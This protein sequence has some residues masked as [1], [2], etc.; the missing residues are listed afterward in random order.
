MKKRSLYLVLF[1]STVFVLTFVKARAASPPN[2]YVEIEINGPVNEKPELY[3]FIFPRYRTMN[4]Y[5]DLMEKAQDDPEIGGVILK[6]SQPQI[7]WAKIQQIRRSIHNFR[8]SGKK[9]YAI[10]TGESLAG[11]L[12]ACA[13]DKITLIPSSPLM[14]TGLRME[15]Y[16]IKDLLEKLGIEVDVIPIG[17]YKTAAETFTSSRMSDA[18]REMLSAILNDYYD[19]LVGFL[20]QDRDLTTDTV[21]QLLDEGPFTPQ[22][23]KDKGLVDSLGYSQDLY[24]EIE[25]GLTRYLKVIRDYDRPKS[26]APTINIFTFLFQQPLPEPQDRPKSRIA[27][28]IASGAIVPGQREDYPFQ[29]EIIAS[30]D[31]IEQIRE[32]MDD[33]SIAAI[34]LRIDSPGGS[35]MASDMIWRM[36]QK[37]RE[38]KPVIASLSDVAASGGYYIAVGADKIVAEPGTITGSIGVITGKP[39]LADLFDKIGVH[40]EVISRGKNSGLFSPA[41]PFSENQRAAIEKIS[42]VVY[43]DFVNKVV[44]SRKLSR[45]QVLSS[46]EGRVWT[47][48]QALERRLVD[49]LGGIERAIELAKEMAGIPAARHVKIEVFP[50]QL[51]IFEF[52]QEFLRGGQLTYAQ[53]LPQG[54]SS[55]LLFFPP[56]A[57]RM[58]I[59]FHVFQKEPTLALFP[60]YFNLK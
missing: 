43:N 41:F 46:A 38:K 2:K 37:A 14:I 36:L 19:Q 35:A 34:I 17:K 18:S 49:E 9:A 40:V 4:Q 42:L 54:M 45:Q 16:Y 53:A 8:K 23:A 26:E 28:V 6:I 56:L 20:V 15:S 31:L 11:Y 52:I 27:L 10:L 59:L 57:K 25:D 5:I 44:Q 24:Q 22:E 39:V 60:Y 55:P 30:A 33:S 48:N 29:E 13:C 7:G 47:G 21:C 32:C 3:E 12:V 1:F 58:I 51:G 50:R